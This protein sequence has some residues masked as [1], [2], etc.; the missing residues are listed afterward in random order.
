MVLGKDIMNGSTYRLME[1]FYRKYI[2]RRKGLSVCD[3]GSCDVNGTFKP[4]FNK[5]KYI[6]V[7]I[8]KGPNVDIVVDKYK[9]PFKDKIFN[10]VISGATVEHVKDIFKW[11]VELKRITMKN[12]TLCIIGPSRFQQHRHPV[13][14]WRILPDG[15]KFLLGEIA[16]LNVLEIKEDASNRRQVMCMGVARRI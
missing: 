12:G 8:V 9:Y 3:V 2:R 4:I 10:V 1:D 11:I 15:M 16:G 13:D 14:C 7:D 6:G 5:H